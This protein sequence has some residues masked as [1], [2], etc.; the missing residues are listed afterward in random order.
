MVVRNAGKDESV[1]AVR[2]G[3][4]LRS[5]RGMKNVGSLFD[6][7]FHLFLASASNTFLFVYK[8]RND[9]FKFPNLYRFVCSPHDHG[10]TIA[11]R[12]FQWCFSSSLIIH[13]G[14]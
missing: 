6:T 7:I 11:K 3:T 8:R 2:L 9:T 1:V 5:R 13:K 12:V 4:S 10:K 14:N